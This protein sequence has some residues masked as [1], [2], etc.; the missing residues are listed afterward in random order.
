MFTILLF[1]PLADDSPVDRVW[2]AK[3]RRSPAVE[4]RRLP[5]GA[6]ATAR[7]PRS[8]PRRMFIELSPVDKPVRIC[9][10]Q[11]PIFELRDLFRDTLCVRV[12]LRCYKYVR[13]FF[14]SCYL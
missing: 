4:L 11:L 3:V 2:S 5:L 6:C 14:F 13:N 9:C 10:Y 8:G 1:S 7:N 12:L